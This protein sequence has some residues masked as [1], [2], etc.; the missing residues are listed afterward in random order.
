MGGLAVLSSVVGVH[1]L[2]MINV[3]SL[4]KYFR[5]LPLKSTAA[6]YDLSYSSWQMYNA[7]EPEGHLSFVSAGMFNI[8]FIH[9]Y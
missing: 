2:I 3:T 7:I 8:G 9:S 4:G 1:L 6:I 5:L